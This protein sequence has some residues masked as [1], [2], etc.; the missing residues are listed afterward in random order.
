MELE[1]NGAIP[2]RAQRVAEGGLEQQDRERERGR[3]DERGDE[4]AGSRPAAGPTGT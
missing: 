4:T 2:E 1:R 3:A